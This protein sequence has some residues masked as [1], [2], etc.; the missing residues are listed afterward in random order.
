MSVIDTSLNS[1]VTSEIETKKRRRTLPREIHGT[2]VA[3]NASSNSPLATLSSS[4]TSNEINLQ[5]C[6]FLRDG[7]RYVTRTGRRKALPN[8]LE[9]GVFDGSR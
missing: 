8:I 3:S 1:S 7:N 6:F 4:P 5:L 9:L 2:V